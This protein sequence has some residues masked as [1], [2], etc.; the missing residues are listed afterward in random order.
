MQSTLERPQADNPEELDQF[1]EHSEQH[2]DEIDKVVTELPNGDKMYNAR[3]V[4]DSEQHVI[5][6]TVSKEAIQH[7]ER[8]VTVIIDGRTDDDQ[9]TIDKVEELLEINEADVLDTHEP[10]DNENIIGEQT[11]DIGAEIRDQVSRELQAET[12]GVAANKS[13]ADRRIGDMITDT[14]VKVDGTEQVVV[15]KI[16]DN[17]KEVSNAILAEQ[18]ITKNGDM[19]STLAEKMRDNGDVSGAQRVEQ[20]AYEAQQNV[21]GGAAELANDD[22]RLQQIG[23]TFDKEIQRAGTSVAEL[24][25]EADQA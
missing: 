1:D 11:G 14:Q 13:I 12:P 8:G 16:Q 7:G 17:R 22:M 15:D 2:E 25:D 4:N 19:I 3:L 10:T 5:Q 24:E 9:E 18:M 23:K 21:V 6:V 20:F